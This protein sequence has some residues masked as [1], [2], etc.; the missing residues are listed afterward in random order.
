MSSESRQTAWLAYAGTLPFIFCAGAPWLG[1]P[2]LPGVG[3]CTEI[4]AAYGVA[5]VS[6]MAG[7]H[8]GTYLYQ[9]AR[10]PLNLFLTSNAIT[11]SVWLAFILTPVAIALAVLLGAFLVL[12]SIDTRL[13]QVRLLS[14]DYMR[15]R[16][17]VTAIVVTMLVITFAAA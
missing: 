4:A 10:I 7:A 11:V 9:S 12:L 5:I 13:A 2:V 15:M 3:P 17:N 6:F 16:R 1:L 14:D 8:W